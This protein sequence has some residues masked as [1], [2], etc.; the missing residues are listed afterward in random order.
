ME[1]I[2]ALNQVEAHRTAELEAVLLQP[3]NQT[4]RLTH[5]EADAILVHAAVF[6]EILVVVVFHPQIDVGFAGILDAVLLL[7]GGFRRRNAA[8]RHNDV[9]VRITHRK[10]AL[11]LLNVFRVHIFP[12]QA[13]L[14]GYFL[15]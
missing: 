14:T 10:R 9:I 3:V 2:H 5:H 8:A 12:P 7:L 13:N 6:A 11:R 15:L 1:A 4:R